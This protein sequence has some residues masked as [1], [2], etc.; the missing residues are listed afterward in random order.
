MH[1]CSK[2]FHKQFPPFVTDV[3]LHINALEL[4]TLVVALKVWGGACKGQRIR[5]F[6][7]N[8]ASVCV[9]NTGKSR[10]PF[11]QACLREICFLAATNEFEVRAVHLAGAEN[12][13]PDLLSR[14]HLSTHYQQQFLQLTAQ[15]A[16]KQVLIDDNLFRFSHSW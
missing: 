1:Q 8:S 3:A 12:R 4:L 14:W 7:D 15:S 6:C 2:Y 10:D 5:V 16:A 9:L 13:L 11:L